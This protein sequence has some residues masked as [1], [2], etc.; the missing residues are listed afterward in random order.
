MSSCAR[1]D[2]V[3]VGDEQL[4]SKQHGG[5]RRRAVALELTWWEWDTSGRAQIDTVG[6]T[7]VDRLTS[8]SMILTLREVLTKRHCVLKARLGL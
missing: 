2:V 8:G 3:G 4:G 1:I 7:R 5:D 6:V